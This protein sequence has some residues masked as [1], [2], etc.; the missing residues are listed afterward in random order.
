MLLIASALSEELD[1]A[2]GLCTART[3]AAVPGARVWTAAYKGTSVCFLRTGVGP[4]KSGR[5]LGKTLESF[6]PSRILLIGYGGALS[7]DLKLGDIT[8][9]RRAS[10]LGGEGK[11]PLEET[12]IEGTWDLAES[13]R[14]MQTAR[15]EGIPARLCDSLTV[16]VIIGDPG[17]KRFLHERFGLAVID[18]ETA[19]LARAASRTGIPVS[20]VRAVSD[21]AEDTFLAPFSYDPAVTRLE[22][23]ARILARGNWV[24]GYGEWRRHAA[25]AREALRCFLKAHLE[26]TTI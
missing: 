13:L 1:I 23:A 15:E 21:E 25:R 9:I 11:I 3:R 4:Q 24:H 6:V 2:A 12:Q 10:L 18:M 14:L 16:P 22:R 19:V 7:E 17:Q 8:V 26:S 5:A 20:C